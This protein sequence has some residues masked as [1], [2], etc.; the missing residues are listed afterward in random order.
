MVDVELF[1]EEAVL[2]EC[3]LDPRVALRLQGTC[4][5]EAISGLTEFSCSTLPASEE[6]YG[7]CR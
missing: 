2:D 3:S 7:S 6:R 5:Q 1:S 4:K